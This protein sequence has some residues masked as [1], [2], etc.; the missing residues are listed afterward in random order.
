MDGETSKSFEESTVKPVTE[1]KT[2][3]P[4]LTTFETRLTED[5]LSS[6]SLFETESSVPE[7]FHLSPLLVIW[8]PKHHQQFIY[9]LRRIIHIKKD[10]K[11][12]SSVTE[13]SSSIPEVTTTKE[14]T[15]EAETKIPLLAETTTQKEDEKTMSSESSKAEST[16]PS[17]KES[18]TSEE[19]TTGAEKFTETIENE[20]SVKTATD[21]TEESL[22]EEVPRSSITKLSESTTTRILESSTDRIKSITEEEAS[23]QTTEKA[24]ELITHKDIDLSF[25]TTESPTKDT[26]TY[27]REK[28]L[29]LLHIDQQNYQ[30]KPIKV[31]K[32]HC[33]Y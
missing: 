32:L 27:T 31:S 11:L 8:N 3:R 22:E 19:T 13:T 29:N 16:T 5:K 15:S 20:P 25:Q 26:E 10:L 28:K 17:T 18:V 6:Q 23:A 9:L 24:P 1:S 7:K 2:D 21:F 14:V 33:P 12:S 30:Q 4:L